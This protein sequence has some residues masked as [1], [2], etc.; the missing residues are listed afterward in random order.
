MGCYWILG[1]LNYKVEKTIND[2]SCYDDNSMIIYHNDTLIT[3]DA[4]FFIFNIEQQLIQR[5]LIENEIDDEL[6]VYG[7]CSFGDHY[8]II[9]GNSR[10]LDVYDINDYQNI[11]SRPVKDK[12]LFGIINDES[13]YLFCVSE[14]IFTFLINEF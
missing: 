6:E 11:A 13:G 7:I 2:V 14:S 10:R 12:F 5:I 9:G 4:S 8:I 1:Y 3:T